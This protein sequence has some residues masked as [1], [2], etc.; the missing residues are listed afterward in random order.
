MS[1]TQGQR[2]QAIRSEVERRIQTREWRPGERIPDEVELAAEFGCA[3]A[4]VNRAL[5]DLADAGLL[6]R[7]RKAG[8]RVALHP[9]RK[10][11]VDIPVV[12]LEVEASGA[13]Y[14]HALLSRK[15]RAP[16]PE[17]AQALSVDPDQ[18]LLHLVAIHSADNAPFILEDRW[19]NPAAVA[20]IVDVDFD[21][22]SANEWLVL[23]APFTSGTFAL[24]AAMAS[25]TEAAH[26][27][28]N[29][30]DA[31]FVAER[32]TWIGARPITTV[33]MSYRPGY[34]LETGI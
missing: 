15:V 28:C 10:A 18:P 20:G 34:R 22:V 24:T 11:M 29:A 31:L 5:Q 33:R 2:W 16:T 12:R 14:G 6:N 27:D 13:R 19:I 9:V 21:T 3:R 26:L 30:G 7:R 17:L 23:N 8:T 4:T 25:A 1:G 32:T